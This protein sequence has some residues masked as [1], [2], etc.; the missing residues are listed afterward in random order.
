MASNDIKWTFFSNYGH[1]YFLIAIHQDITLREIANRV[2]ITER[3]VLGIVQELEEA[4]Y[5]KK[6]KVG[7]ANKYSI[8]PKKTL[9]HPLESKVKLEDLVSLIEEASVKS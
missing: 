2:G 7:R 9:R 1:I 4:G 3:S 8:L 6:Q 5:V